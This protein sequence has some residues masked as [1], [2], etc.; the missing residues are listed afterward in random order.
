MSLFN[1]VSN[2][3]TIPNQPLDIIEDEEESPYP[4]GT[5]LY[6][7]EDNTDVER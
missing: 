2:F 5:I 7:N 3:F 6:Q 4:F 1:K